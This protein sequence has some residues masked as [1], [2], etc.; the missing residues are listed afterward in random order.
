MMD[1]VD[2]LR[3][4][5]TDDID[6]NLLVRTKYFEM[7]ANFIHFSISFSFFVF[8]FFSLS[9][10]DCIVSRSDEESFSETKIRLEDDE[11]YEDDG[12]GKICVSQVFQ[13][14]QAF[15]FLCKK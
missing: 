11:G 15:G 3:D 12:Q 7:H 6:E 2:D 5:E 8:S 13:V 9:N 4:I 14:F 1:D 10:S